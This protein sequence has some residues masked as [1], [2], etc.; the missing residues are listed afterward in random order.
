MPQ[1]QLPRIDLTGKRY[2]RLRVLAHAGKSLT[3]KKLHLWKCKCMCGTVVIVSGKSLKNGDTKSC[4]CL[5]KDAVAAANSTHGARR[6]TASPGM[7]GA[8]SS[9]TN[10][11]NRCYY[12]GHHK[13]VRYSG[14]GITVC[15]RWHRFKNF[16]EDMGPRPG[17]GFSV[18]RKDNNGN[19]TPSNCRW[20]VAVEQMANTSRSVP[21]THN[22]ITRSASFWEK[23]FGLKKG[24]LIRTLR[25]GGKL[26]DML[27]N[28]EVV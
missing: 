2:V 7:K 12:V 5:H 20:A 11:M 16:L 19:Y 27:P 21:V 13:R 3:T 28:L 8:Y 18:E 15:P 1:S 10:M 24:T 17:P 9:W 26:T 22:G 23:Y 6:A 14:R 4:G 25:R